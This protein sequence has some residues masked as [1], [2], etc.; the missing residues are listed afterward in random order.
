MQE[1]TT[2]ERIKFIFKEINMRR[3]EKNFVTENFDE[4]LQKFPAL[5]A[6]P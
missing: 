1:L 5:L 6:T 4:K 3:T 2:T